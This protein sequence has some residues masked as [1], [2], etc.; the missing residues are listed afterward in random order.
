MY[1]SLIPFAFAQ[2]KGNAVIEWTDKKK[3]LL[4]PAS[5]YPY[6]GKQFPL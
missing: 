2:I 6:F 3:C 1:L 4:R 5:S